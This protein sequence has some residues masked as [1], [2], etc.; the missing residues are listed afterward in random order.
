MVHVIRQGGLWAIHARKK[1]MMYGPAESNRHEHCAREWCTGDLGATREKEGFKY[2]PMEDNQHD[3][4]LELRI[5]K[6]V[7]K[8]RISR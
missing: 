8:S 7:A 3:S 2:E 4:T 1:A 6:N 5:T